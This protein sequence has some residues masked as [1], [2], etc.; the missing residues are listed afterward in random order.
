MS[1]QLSG[2]E[3]AARAET[4]L[5]VPLQHALGAR[6]LDPAD[7]PAGV[8]FTV[9]EL[10][11]NGVGGLHAAALQAVLE[12]AGYLAVLPHLTVAE[13]AVTHAV[14]AQFVSAAAE[15]ELVRAVGT[16]DRRT[17]RVAFL[18]VL[19]TV[20]DQVIARAQLT[21]SVVAMR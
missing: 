10:A 6:L 16:V 1:T 3:L 15:G 8:C 17:R 21:K 12:L 7:P 14:S 5:A 19:A 2:E 11:A 13:H 4:A 9:G 18:S 20:G